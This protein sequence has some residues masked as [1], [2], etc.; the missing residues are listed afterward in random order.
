MNLRDL[1]R[2]LE[3]VNASSNRS[4]SLNDLLSVAS[5]INEQTI[6][7]E[8]K[9]RALIKKLGSAVGKPLSDRDVERII[10]LIRQN[11]DTL[12]DPK[13]ADRVFRKFS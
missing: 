10:G 7:D 4:F 3:K 5:Q 2:L 13:K 6:N 1:N 9:L 8:R 12:T 11:K